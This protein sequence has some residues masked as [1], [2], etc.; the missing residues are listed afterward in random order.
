MQAEM[1]D[2]PQSRH[3]KDRCDV[4]THPIQVLKMRTGH[5]RNQSWNQSVPI[6]CLEKC[7]KGKPLFSM[8]R[9]KGIEPSYAAWEAAV[10][11]LNYARALLLRTC[12]KCPRS[13]HITTAANPGSFN[14]YRPRLQSLPA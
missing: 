3:E 2:S 13:G 12:F 14:Q 8:E 11:P 4:F 1:S 9:A 7:K 10:L 6:R 5:C